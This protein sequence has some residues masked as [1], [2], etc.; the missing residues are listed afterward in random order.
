[1]EFVP[2]YK[3]FHFEKGC[4]YTIGGEFK[5][6]GNHTLN[7][8]AS[9]TIEEESPVLQEQRPAAVAA[10]QECTKNAGMECSP[11]QKNMCCQSIC[12]PVRNSE[13][14]VNWET[15]RCQNPVDWKQ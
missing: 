11:F 7:N 14:K 15:Y 6:S 13:G 9:H 4:K 12:L 2:L 5:C 1:M 10:L 3:Q 8:V